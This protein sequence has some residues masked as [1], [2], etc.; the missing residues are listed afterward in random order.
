MNSRFIICEKNASINI[1]ASVSCDW[2]NS[3]AGFVTSLSIGYA[4]DTKKAFILLVQSW[5]Y[6]DFSSMYTLPR[7][8]I[9]DLGIIF[10]QNINS[11][12][13]LIH[14]LLRFK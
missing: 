2:S 13:L 8:A 11:T 3:L 5:K 7:I 10:I 4:S 1:T 9:Y 12:L 6:V 14:Q